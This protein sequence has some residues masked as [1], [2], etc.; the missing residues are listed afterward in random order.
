M[1]THLIDSIEMAVMAFSAAHVLC[2]KETAIG[3]PPKLWFL[4]HNL[5]NIGFQ[6]LNQPKT[7]PNP[8][9]KTNPKVKNPT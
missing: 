1:T 4:Y 7:N 8:K 3:H 2:K 6:V 5:Q 9:Y